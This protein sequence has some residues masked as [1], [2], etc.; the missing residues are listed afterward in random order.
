M[1]TRYWDR[2]RFIRVPASGP[3]RWQ[4]GG[5]SGLCEI[6]DISP[7]GVGIRLSARKAAQLGERVSL[8]VDL[9]PE[10]TW[11]LAADARIVRRQ[12]DHDGQCVVGVEL[13]SGSWNTGH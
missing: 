3:A 6:V 10:D 1:L 11:H 12:T 2:R 8:A 4:S 9:A 7:G 5:R 13:P